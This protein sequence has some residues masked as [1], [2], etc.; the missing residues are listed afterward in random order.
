M[1][2]PRYAK[3]AD[4]LVGYSCALQEG[5]KILINA[6]DCPEAMVRALIRAT[7]KAGAT[8][9]VNIENYAL[10]RDLMNLMPAPAPAAGRKLHDTWHSAV[11]ILG[12]LDPDGEYTARSRSMERELTAAINDTREAV[13]AVL[14]S[15]E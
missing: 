7:A 3:L 10:I 1:L 4:V 9:L 11:S 6:I 14:K 8:P 5:D 2:D 12:E 13:L 15:L